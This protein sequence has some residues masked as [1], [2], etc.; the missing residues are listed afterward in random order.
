MNNTN[1]PENKLPQRAESTNPDWDSYVAKGHG[2]TDEQI[3]ADIHELLLKESGERT[4]GLAVTVS[5]GVATLRGR[6]SGKAE[7]ERLLARIREIPAVKS[8]TDQLELIEA[9]GYD[10]ARDRVRDVAHQAQE[11]TSDL[12]ARAQD[13]ASDVRSRA[14]EVAS[15]LRTRTHDYAERA[16]EYASQAYD[17]GQRVGARAATGARSVGDF[18]TT[19]ALPLTLVGASLGYLL[20]SIQRER[21]TRL[22]PVEVPYYRT[23]SFAP[24]YERPDFRDAPSVAPTTTGERLLGVRAPRDY[25]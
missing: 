24:T 21:Q 23:R 2:R 20:W 12:R 11:A 14:Q 8:V 6:V 3:R 15:D 17:Y 10:A 1:L 4:S 22:A 9:R 5:G 7:Q 19:H 16:Q 25:R 18:A 13:V